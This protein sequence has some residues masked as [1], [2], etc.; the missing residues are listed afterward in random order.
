MDLETLRKNYKTEILAIAK[1]C[2]VSKYTRI[3]LCS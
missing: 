1:E 2:H 3:W